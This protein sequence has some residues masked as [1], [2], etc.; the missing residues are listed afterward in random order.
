MIACD[1]VEDDWI[2]APPQQ[3]R[4]F[5]SGEIRARPYSTRVFGLAKT[6]SIEHATAE[7]T[8]ISNFTFGFYRFF[9]AIG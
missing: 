5:M 7:G 9:W 1:E 8:S 3:D 2:Y 4:N 6:H